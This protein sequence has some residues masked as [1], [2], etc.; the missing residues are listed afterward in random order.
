MIYVKEI[1]RVTWQ[2]TKETISCQTR[3]RPKDSMR[4]TS[5]KKS[6]EGSSRDISM[7]KKK[8]SLLFLCVIFRKYARSRIDTFLLFDSN[9]SR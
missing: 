8:H 2:K 6:L 7:W 3:M 4:S 9:V 1:L 5:P